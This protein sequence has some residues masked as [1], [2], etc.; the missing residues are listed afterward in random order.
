MKKYFEACK[1]AEELKKAYRYIVKKLHPD[2][3]GR[4]EDFQTMQAEYSAAW[5]RLKD[6]HQTKDGKTYT[7]ETDETA[8]EFME[9]IERLINLEGVD[10][11]LC[12][13]WIWCSGNTK[14]HREIFKKLNFR[15]SVKK[16][17]W[18]FHR[19]PYRKRSKRELS[20]DEIREMYGSQKYKK[21]NEKEEQK[22]I[23]L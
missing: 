4:K 18:Y 15:W 23:A 1:T 11:E 17:A 22:R 8:D 5:E 9:I 14:P 3:G 10:V 19:E 7:K 2:K 6:I 20:L 21:E 13:S 16:S 12:G